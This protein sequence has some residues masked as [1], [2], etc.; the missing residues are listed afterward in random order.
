MEHKCVRKTNTT[1]DVNVYFGLPI[2]P[3]SSA[4]SR[5]SLEN[6][7]QIEEAEKEKSAAFKERE[8][9]CTSYLKKAE[10]KYDFMKRR[11]G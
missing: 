6:Q 5:A 8:G 2:L 10:E 11:K 3:S 9:Q 7:G 4:K 1:S